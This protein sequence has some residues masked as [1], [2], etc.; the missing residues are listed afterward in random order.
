MIRSEFPGVRLDRAEQSRGYIVHRN[1]GAH[2]ASAPIVFSIDD[3]AI[4][5]SPRTVEQT[6]AE[7]NHSRVAAVGIPHI[8]VNKPHIA[9]SIAPDDGKIYCMATYIGC[10]HALRT[11]VFKKLGGYREFLFHQAEE[12]EYCMR[13]YEAGYIVRRGRA[14]VIHHFES[15]KRDHKRQFVQTARNNLLVTWW[16]VPMPQFFPHWFMKHL[17]L[18]S[19]GIKRRHPLWMTQGILTGWAASLKEFGARK[20]VSS[21]T[22][23]LLRR[24]A[25]DRILPLE[26]VEPFLRAI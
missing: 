1:R 3:D 10:A 14:D 20:P 24:M 11:D 26:E 25:Q 8:D 18:M 7:F 9:R 13:L 4:F 17:N 19:F 21:Q 23:K 5:Q 15:P 6:L 2:L 22:Y 16:N 12:G